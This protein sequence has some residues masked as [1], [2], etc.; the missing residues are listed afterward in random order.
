MIHIARADLGADGKAVG[1]N[2][3]DGTW[4]AG[5]GRLAD[6]KAQK[7]SANFDLAAYNPSINSKVICTSPLTSPHLCRLPCTFI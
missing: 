5:P 7:L 1:P 2:I 4:R 3:L 6:F